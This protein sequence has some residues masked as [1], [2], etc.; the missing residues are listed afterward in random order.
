MAFR[1]RWSKEKTDR[2]LAAASRP[3]DGKQCFDI[4][5]YG[6]T[7]NAGA[8]KYYRFALVDSEES[9]AYPLQFIGKPTDPVE[10]KQVGGGG[11]Y[12]IG[13]TIYSNPVYSYSTYS[14]TG[15]ACTKASPVALEKG[16]GIVIEPFFERYLPPA[17]V[18]WVVDPKYSARYAAANGTTE[19]TKSSFN[20]QSALLFE[21]YKKRLSSLT[22]LLHK[23]YPETRLAE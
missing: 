4:T 3:M 8:L 21:K 14:S 5:V 19:T 10:S 12:Q 6:S 1:E 18:A 15:T 13:N 9:N 20:P 22:A 11:I 17:D 7:R 16:F 2:A 23:A